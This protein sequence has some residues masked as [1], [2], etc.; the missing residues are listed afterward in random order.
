MCIRDFAIIDRSTN[1]V[2]AEHVYLVMQGLAKFHAISFALKDQQPEKFN[3][4]T[5]N[6]SEVVISR[7][8]NPLR[9]CLNHQAKLVFDAVSAEEDVHL[10]ARVEEFY[11]KEA[12]D[13]AADCL[14]L[15]WTGP[16]SVIA[17][18]DV[19]Q[20]NI[21]FRY[22]SNGKPIEVCFLDWQAARHSSPVIDI[23]FFIFCC[24]TKGLRDIHYDTF[25]KVY[26][27][28]LSTHIRR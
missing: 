26:H 15:E 11:R 4:L 17:Y 18:G 14:D 9:L 27:E 3:K 2:T 6:F 16:A 13:T 22:D 1:S 10:L 21:M 25:L 19:H 12:I 8:N 20:N 5:S 24:T 7:S 28:S 23:A